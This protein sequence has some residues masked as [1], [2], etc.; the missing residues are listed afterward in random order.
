MLENILTVEN[1][2]FGMGILIAAIL[3][4]QG[5]ILLNKNKKC[6]CKIIG[7]VIDNVQHRARDMND[8]W[9]NY[10]HSLCEYNVD[11]VKCVRET[12]I[13]TREPKYQ[14]GQSVEIYYNPNNCHEAYIVGDRNN[15]ALG[16]VLIVLSFLTILI[17]TIFIKLM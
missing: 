4:I 10:W 8:H 3:F 16:G 5:I 12:I 14:V 2:I 9:V 15:K 11:G 17:S 6:T 7:K 13:G 1:M